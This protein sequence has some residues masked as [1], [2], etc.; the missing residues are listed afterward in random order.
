MNYEGNLGKWA[1][2]HWK[3]RDLKSI[4]RSDVYDVVTQFPGDELTPH[5]KRSLLKCIKRIFQMAL[6]DAIIDRNPAIG[7]K[8]QVPEV[9][10]CKISLMGAR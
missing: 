4:T 10:Q 2:P 8:V 9:E 3:D 5:S 7:I 1:T 6:E